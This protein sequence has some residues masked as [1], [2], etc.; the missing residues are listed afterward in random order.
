MMLFVL[1]VF[2]PNWSE[3]LFLGSFIRMVLLTY[4]PM[5]VMTNLLIF[6]MLAS[7]MLSL[8]NKTSSLILLLSYLSRSIIVTYRL[9]AILMLLYLMLVRKIRI[10]WSMGSPSLM[11]RR[12]DFLRRF[13][14][15]SYSL[16]LYPFMKLLSSFLIWS[17]IIR[18]LSLIR[19]L[20][21]LIYDDLDLML[22]PSRLFGLLQLH[23]LLCYLLLLSVDIFGF[24]HLC[25]IRV[26]LPFL[27]ILI[28]TTDVPGLLVKRGFN[29]SLL[30]PSSF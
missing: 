12:I 19:L 11:R 16:M 2:L 30:I 21:L 25:L 5:L 3:L 8:Q 10:F 15:E 4:M 18:S 26:R 27:G 14:L 13:L 1:V 24:G 6:G 28:D 22:F 7:L 29:W 20:I 17:W 23:R 9:H